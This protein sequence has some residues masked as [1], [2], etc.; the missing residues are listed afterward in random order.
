M[1]ITVVTSLYPTAARPFEGIFAARRWEGMLARGHAVRIVH[2]LPFAPVPMGRYRD[3]AR[4]A[5][6]E[7]R[8][9][10]QIVHP[11]HLHVPGRP[12]GNATRFARR[13]LA[14]IERGPRPD[15]V[16]C[17]YA[18]PAAALAPLLASGGVARIPCVV[19]GR[20]SDV[21][22]VAG[23]AGLGADL[24]ACLWAADGWCAVS[25]DLVDT[26]DRLA[27]RT[28]EQNGGRL[29]A[30]G[31]DTEL[32]VPGDRAAAR[33][34]LGQPTEGPLVL[35]VGH[36]IP[37]K[38]PLLALDAFLR[39]APPDARLVFLGRGPLAS[40]LEARVAVAG[41]GARVTLAG[42]RPP[43]EL[44]DWYQSAD[45]LLLTSRREGRPNVVLEALASG[46]P[47]LATAAGGTGE[48]LDDP[49]WL[50]ADRDPAGLAQ[51]LALLLESPPTAADLRQ[52][53]LPLSWSQSLTTLEEWLTAI[54]SKRRLEAGGRR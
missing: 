52:R 8:G 49:R 46:L 47:V 40:E 1:Q 22:Q 9:G 26:M 24:A 21:L 14:R 18:W 37:R 36:L 28:G 5:R 15:I 2:P 41:A 13:A 31:V 4:T 33:A 45:L 30:N 7:V 19:N 53:V 27:G 12:R 3:I 34:R 11:R 50:A 54:I 35:V 42:E 20:G 25:Q 43:E 6:E 48:L 32:F 44:R 23:E 17:D 16:V 10:I 39:G 29:I 38:D 51:K